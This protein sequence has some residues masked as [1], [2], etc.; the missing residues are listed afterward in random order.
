MSANA[1]NYNWDFKP[2]DVKR[3]FDNEI[4]IFSCDVDDPRYNTMGHK[5]NLG[6]SW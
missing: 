2:A 1:L 3:C 4:V 6:I 5:F